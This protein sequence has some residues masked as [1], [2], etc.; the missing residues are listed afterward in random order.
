[1]Y[2]FMHKC[3]AQYRLDTPNGETLWPD[4]M[5]FFNREHGTATVFFAAN[6]PKFHRWMCETFRQEGKLGILKGAVFCAADRGQPREMTDPTV[7][8]CTAENYG[9]RKLQ[10]G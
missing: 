1:M 8:L 4:E 10:G 6:L 3:D 9:V 5:K 2:S 7:D